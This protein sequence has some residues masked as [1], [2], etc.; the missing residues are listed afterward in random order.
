MRI[1]DLNDLDDEELAAALRACVDIDSW[2]AAL[3]GG[4][5]YRDAGALL[6]LARAHASAWTSAEVLGALADHPRIGER[7]AGS[8]AGAAHSAR[9]Q[10]GVDAR[11]TELAERL[12]A[13][14]LAYEERFGRIYLVRAKGR[15][16]AEL[17]ALLEQRLDN[18]EAT[19][20]AVT[21]EQ[22]GEIAVL[23]LVDLLDL[24]PATVGGPR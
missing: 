4:R 24:D 21:R 18:D 1:D 13:G 12:R 7:P 3:L 8:E 15:T 6:D 19:E 10:A 23:R 5:P 20:L 9:E 22:L 11:D 2:V 16:G 17:L 14:N